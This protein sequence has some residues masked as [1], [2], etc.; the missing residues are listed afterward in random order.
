VLDLANIKHAKES[1]SF[2]TMLWEELDF[3]DDSFDLV[4]CLDPETP[5]TDPNLLEEVSRVLTDDGEYV[6]AI[7]RRTID[8]FESLLPKYG[9]TAPAE[10]VQLGQRDEQAPQIGQL[11]KYFDEQVRIL[12]RPEYNYVFESENADTE[13]EQE[14]APVDYTL[15]TED[16]HIA[17]VELLFCGP[18]SMDEPSRRTIR[19]PYYRL[20]ERLGTVIRDLNMRQGPGHDSQP[21]SGPVE[22]GRRDEETNPQIDAEWDEDTDVRQR[23]DRVTRRQ[24][25]AGD[26]VDDEIERLTDNYRRLQR[27]LHQLREETQSAMVAQERSIDQL[28]E[29]LTRWRQEELAAEQPSPADG[30]DVDEKAETGIFEV[31]DVS[32]GDAEPSEGLGERAE[33]DIYEKPGASDADKAGESGGDDEEAVEQKVEQLLEEREKQKEYIDELEDKIARL[34]GDDASEESSDDEGS[35]DE[36]DDADDADESTE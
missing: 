27:S 4:C 5:V 6:C 8:G 24:N 31:P 17:G 3:P 16:S 19:L 14:S 15:C 32:D 34:E 29:L 21:L 25:E 2:H 11:G 36:A 23:P 35:D 10:N 30:G 7:E 28:V 20:T 9:Y 1:L 12:Q 33:T 26:A 18:E 22:S 13:D